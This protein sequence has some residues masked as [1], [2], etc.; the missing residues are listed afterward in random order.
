MR[1][2]NSFFLLFFLFCGSVVRPAVIIF[3]IGD[4]LFNVSSSSRFTM[5][6]NELGLWD[7]IWHRVFERQDI[8]Q[9]VFNFLNK[10]FGIQNPEQGCLPATQGDN[11][12]LPQIMCN[13][14][15][16]ANLNTTDDALLT[17]EACIKQAHE[18]IATSKHLKSKRERRLAKKI[19]TAMFTPKTLAQYTHPIPAAAKLLAECAAQ[20]DANGQPK[21]TFFILSNY[22]SKCFLALVDQPHAHEIF[23]YFDLEHH[24]IISGNCH[25]IKPYTSIYNHLKTELIAFDS[26]FTNETYLAENC[27]FI[28][29]QISN[30][31]EGRKCGIK[32]SLWLSHGDYGKLRQEFIDLGILDA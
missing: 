14:L 12:I 32:Q 25:T 10:E 3:D 7:L 20:K 9:V 6:R 30:V 1:N 27:V 22:S 29:D 21:H 26:R 16:N 11:E 18:R 23:Q 8:K 24:A 4:V 15:A 5:G 2:N 19:I 13:W 31:L 28:D 17:E